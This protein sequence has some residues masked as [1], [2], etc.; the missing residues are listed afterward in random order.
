MTPQNLLTKSGATPAKLA[1]VAVLAVSLIVVL[2]VQFGSGADETVAAGDA[3]QSPSAKQ[4]RTTATKPPAAPAKT[5]SETG[6]RQRCVWPSI[7]PDEVAAFNPFVL[8]ESLAATVPAE[9]VDE[10]AKQAD[11]ARLV[12]EER[13]RREQLRQRRE[14][15]LS[16]L[17]GQGAHVVVMSDKG[18][19]AIVGDRR[20]RVGDTIEG[21][22]VKDINASGV[23]LEQIDQ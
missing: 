21:L 13:K 10:I 6:V 15:V 23:I 11:E 4:N 20:L 17:K 18:P 2:M 14:A 22:R 1:L 5:A 16:E 8:P 19:I 12:E 3:K 9:Q 7:E